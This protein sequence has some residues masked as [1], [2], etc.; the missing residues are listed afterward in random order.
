MRYGQT[1]VILLVLCQDLSFFITLPNAQTMGFGLPSQQLLQLDFK[2]KQ[3]HNEY[4]K[5]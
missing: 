5:F 3:W 2:R 4:F 1:T